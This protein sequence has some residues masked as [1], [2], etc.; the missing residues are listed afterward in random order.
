MFKSPF[1]VILVSLC[2]M[3]HITLLLIV[4]K[5]KRIT[6]IEKNLNNK[7]NI[8]FYGIVDLKISSTIP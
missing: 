5:M 6:I 1:T 4:E 2:K 8:F 7:L 3:L